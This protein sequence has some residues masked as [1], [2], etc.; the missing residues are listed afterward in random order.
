MIGSTILFEYTLDIPSVRH[1]K[2]M[3]QYV[4]TIFGGR[5]ISE[6]TT[7]IE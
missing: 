2:R 7:I 1:T 6:Q 3:Q 5:R 4:L